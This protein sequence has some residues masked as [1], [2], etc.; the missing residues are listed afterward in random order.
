VYLNREV[1]PIG[2]NQPVH[3]YFA[4]EFVSTATSGTG[5]F[6]PLLLQVH[7]HLPPNEAIKGL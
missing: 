3:I 1:N 6:S 5:R 2:P 7:L 4:G